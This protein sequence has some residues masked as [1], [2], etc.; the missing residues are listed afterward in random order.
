MLDERFNNVS[1]YELVENLHNLK[2]MGLVE[3]YVNKFE[4]LIS[5][6]QR[7]NPTL[8]HSYYLSSFISGLRPNIKYQVQCHKP[9]ALTDA[10]WYAKRLEQAHP[11]FKKFNTIPVPPKV[12]KNWNRDK[13]PTDTVNPSI[14]ELKVAGKCFK[15]REPWVPGHTKVC[16]AKNFFSRVFRTEAVVDK[17]IVPSA[18]CFFPFALS[19]RPF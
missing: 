4:E 12:Q 13:E 2:Q 3:E 9:L 11:P 5:A 19:V 17:Y 16:K 18:S 14:A 7:T 6:V 8:P 1:E 15:C 10:Y